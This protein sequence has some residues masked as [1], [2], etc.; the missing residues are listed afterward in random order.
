MPLPC[1]YLC[2]LIL[3]VIIGNFAAGFIPDKIGRKPMIR[4]S[5][6]VLFV[7]ITL[8][9]V[10]RTNQLLFG[11]K[12][13]NG[14][15][16]GAL[17]SVTFTYLGEIAPLALRGILTAAGPFS[18]I[19]GSFMVYLIVNCQGNQPSRWAYRG[20]FVGQ[21]AITGIATILLP[22]MPE[23]VSV[24]HFLLGA[25]LLTAKEISLAALDSKQGSKSDSHSQAVSSDS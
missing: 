17:T 2:L 11:G 22:F 13:L 23:C 14:F 5:Y 21:Y 4:I 19:L 6:V 7:G 3:D 12:F 18:F 9:T 20:A 16:V 1:I 24:I 25:I 8:E 15:A 10:A